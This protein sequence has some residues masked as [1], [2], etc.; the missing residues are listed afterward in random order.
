M[1]STQPKALFQ[2]LQ[3]HKILLNIS[4]YLCTVYLINSR[5]V[6][7]INKQENT[8]KGP[9][10]SH[11]KGITI[12]ELLKMFPDDRAPLKTGS[13]KQRWPRR[14]SSVQNAVRWNHT[15]MLTTRLCAIV[16][17]ETRCRQFFSVQAKAPLWKAQTSNCST[18]RLQSTWS[19]RA[20]RVSPAS[21]YIES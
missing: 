10:K 18:G 7:N 8:V 2:Y 15:H 6:T 12:I 19:L 17:K 4:K 13:K 1:G 9:G 5:I 16:V 11:R 3:Y 14:S 20:S 21:S